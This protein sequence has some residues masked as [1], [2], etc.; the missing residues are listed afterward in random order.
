M[1]RMMK[2]EVIVSGVCSLPLPKELNR[3]SRRTRL[4][5]LLVLILFSV[6]FFKQLT[7]SQIS[8]PGLSNTKLVVWGAIGFNQ[9][10]GKHWTATTY[11]GISRESDPDSWS[12][13][14]KQA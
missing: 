2:Y 14:H 4:F 6:C 3:N 7:Y 9:H 11:L 10:L 5:R 12:F 8:P 1:Q 13:L